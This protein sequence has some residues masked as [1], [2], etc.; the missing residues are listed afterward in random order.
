LIADRRRTTYAIDG[1]SLPLD[2]WPRDPFG[3]RDVPL[4]SPNTP[5]AELSENRTAEAPMLAS[6]AR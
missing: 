1:K 6:S 3:F 4:P 2:V 5:A